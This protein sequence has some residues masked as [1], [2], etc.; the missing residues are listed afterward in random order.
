MSE[1]RYTGQKQ[2][3][4]SHL[5]QLQRGSGQKRW[6]RAQA[7]PRNLTLLRFWTLPR[8]PGARV[9]GSGAQRDRRGCVGQASYQA[10]QNAERRLGQHALEQQLVRQQVP[11][12]GASVSCNVHHVSSMPRDERRNSQRALQQQ[13]V[14]QVAVQAL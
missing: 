12:G 13:L 9:P 1:V 2:N 6:A 4:G 8:P 3:A 10:E 7:R 11:A 14:C 5:R